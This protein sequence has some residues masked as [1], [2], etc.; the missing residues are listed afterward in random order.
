VVFLIV[1]V[2]GCREHTGLFILFRVIILCDNCLSSHSVGFFFIVVT[3]LT[4]DSCQ[5]K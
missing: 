5:I 4:N 1:T 2:A 3:L